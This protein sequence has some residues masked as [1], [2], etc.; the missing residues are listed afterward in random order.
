MQAREGASA[1]AH[2][3]GSAIS[4]EW[5][6]VRASLARRPTQTLAGTNPKTGQA[7]VTFLISTVPC[8]SRM[9]GPSWLSRS[10]LKFA[11][12]VSVVVRVDAL[13]MILF[14]CG[15]PSLCWSSRCPPLTGSLC[16][17]PRFLFSA[18]RAGGVYGW[19]CFSMRSN[20]A[21]GLGSF[22]EES[23]SGSSCGAGAMEHFFADA[24]EYHTRVGVDDGRIYACL[25]GSN[26]LYRFVVL[27]LAVLLTSVAVCVEEAL[28]H[29]RRGLTIG[30]LFD[31]FLPHTVAVDTGVRR[32][33]RLYSFSMYRVEED[34]FGT[35]QDAPKREAVSLHSAPK[36]TI[37]D[38]QD[39]RTFHLRVRIVGR[40]HNGGA[41]RA[42]TSPTLRPHRCVVESMTTCN[43]QH[44]GQ[45]QFCSHPTQGRAYGGTEYM[46][47]LRPRHFPFEPLARP[48]VPNSTFHCAHC[49][50]T[51]RRHPAT[52]FTRSSR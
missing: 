31:V 45:R 36:V 2:E 38:G 1:H 21:R 29:D 52:G 49:I 30:L 8:S 48:P 16:C 13:R 5:R 24:A 11:D 40:A 6:T 3:K 46:V 47:F 42:G 9:S 4:R 28:E 14:S 18:F 51:W 20:R 35:W 43:G 22:M 33:P 50:S 44:A 15:L 25:H 12:L 32:K 39:D 10:L 27:P 41:H 7:A 26:I 17:S 19:W 34:R 37:E 23:L